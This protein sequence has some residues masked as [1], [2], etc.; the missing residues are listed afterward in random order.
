VVEAPRI[1]ALLGGVERAPLVLLPGLGLGL[2]LGLAFHLNANHRARQGASGDLPGSPAR[3]A[4]GV[5]WLASYVTLQPDESGTGR[6][7]VSALRITLP[8]AT[9]GRLKALLERAG[10]RASPGGRGAG[11]SPSPPP[12][13]HVATAALPSVRSEGP[14][15]TP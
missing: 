10:A 15:S 1:G 9:E 8:K 4:G 14:G 3:E 7:Q 13:R 6:V 2:A 11:G 12:A 5:S